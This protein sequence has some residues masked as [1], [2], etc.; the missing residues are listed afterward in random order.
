LPHFTMPHRM[1]LGWIDPTWIKLYNFAASGG[2][3]V[4]ETVTLHAVE[5]CPPPA[6]RYAGIEIRIADGWN[7]YLEY[8]KG[9]GVQIGDRQLP[10]D[11]AVLL[12]DVTSTGYAAPITRPYILEGMDDPVLT[13]SE[14]YSETDFTDPTYPTDFKISVSGIDGTKAEVTIQYGVN[15]K[16]DPS[17]RPWPASPD[18][19][20]QSPDIEVQNARNLA[21]PAWFNVPWTGHQNTIIAQ[22]KN[23]G[24]LD[25]PSVKANFS[26]KDYT[27]GGVLETP[28]GSDTH[29]VDAL[30]TVPFQTVW[31][32]TL[33]E[34]YCIIDYCFCSGNMLLIC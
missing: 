10:T 33:G 7:Y 6:G 18:R 27:V 34:H 28:L 31:T 3:P 14:S 24:N 13:N 30:A 4:N 25:A 32:P 2:A 12:T 15:S 11:S 22:I 23:A 29:D 17:I 26:V 16:P 1:M 20:Y 21:D 8:R 5:N 19:Q 9:Q